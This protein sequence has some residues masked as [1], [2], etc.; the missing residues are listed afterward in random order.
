[1]GRQGPGGGNRSCTRPLRRRAAR[2]RHG[3]RTRHPVADRTHG[4]V[5]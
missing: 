2:D 4:A 1:V 5:L 3:Q